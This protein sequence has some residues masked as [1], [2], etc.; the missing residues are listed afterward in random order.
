[1]IKFQISYFQMIKVGDGPHYVSESKEVQ[2]EDE[3]N[4]S[5]QPS[6]PAR[7]KQ[8]PRH[9][10]AEVDANSR[11]NKKPVREAYI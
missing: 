7:T 8:M 11:T 6:R 1:M 10:L 3:P 9:L 2:R 5:H 4:L